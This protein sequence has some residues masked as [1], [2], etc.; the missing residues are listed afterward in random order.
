M[1][2]GQLHTNAPSTRGSDDT[3]FF[4][5]GLASA[6]SNLCK[7]DVRGCAVSWRSSSRLILIVTD[8]DAQ[9]WRHIS[10]VTW[11]L[12][13]SARYFEQ[14]AVPSWLMGPLM[15]NGVIGVTVL[16]TVGNSYIV[17]PLL[18]WLM[19]TVAGYSCRCWC[20]GLNMWR[21]GP[22]LMISEMLFIGQTI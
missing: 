21:L 13:C 17:M 5:S 20:R 6:I 14:A 4:C 15:D 1:N 8:Y 3:S 2:A 22:T 9:Y 19:A 18:F 7:C 10:G 11:I 12:S 16:A